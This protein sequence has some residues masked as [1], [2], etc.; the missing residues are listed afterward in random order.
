[1]LHSFFEYIINLGQDECKGIIK[2]NTH[3]N[4]PAKI[5]KKSFKNDVISVIKSKIPSE[6]VF[7][8][9][10]NIQKTP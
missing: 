2:E 1:M 5:H 3:A 8:T 9:V 7:V 6:I 10:V 4:L